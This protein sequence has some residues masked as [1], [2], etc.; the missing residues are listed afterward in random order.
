[1]RN[2]PSRFDRRDC[3]RSQRAAKVVRATVRR[4]AIRSARVD[5]ERVTAPYNHAERDVF[6]PMWWGDAAGADSSDLAYTPMVAGNVHGNEL[7]DNRAFISN[8]TNVV[9]SSMASQ[10]RELL[11]TAPPALRACLGGQL[12]RVVARTREPGLRLRRPARDTGRELRG[13]A[14]ARDRREAGQRRSAAGPEGTRDGNRARC[15]LGVAHAVASERETPQPHGRGAVPEAIGV[16]SV[17]RVFVVVARCERRRQN[18]WRSASGTA[19]HQNGYAQSE[20]LQIFQR[21][22]R[23]PPGDRGLSCVRG[24]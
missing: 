11:S 2:E 5:G 21:E 23:K 24:E 20:S 16:G 6:R 7:A 8:P 17:S 10:M 22:K 1:M 19:R 9:D 18:V 4:P 12:I 3:D 14:P 13:T 15:R